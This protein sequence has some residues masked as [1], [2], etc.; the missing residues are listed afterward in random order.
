MGV[1][2]S[3]TIAPKVDQITADHL[4][5]SGPITGKVLKVYSTGSTEQ[6]VAIQLSCHEQPYKPCKGMRVVL[7]GVWGDNTGDEYIGRSMRLFRN[8]DV[9][10]GGIAVGGVEI[11]HV[12][13]I[14]KAMGIPIR[15][16]KG[17]KRNFIVEPLRDAD[18]SP[19]SQKKPE[20][21]KP[22]SHDAE[23]TSLLAALDKVTDQAG[24]DAL[25]PKVAELWKVITKE[26]GEKITAKSKEAK[27]RIEPKLA[28]SNE[29]TE[30]QHAMANR[31]ATL[32]NET[33]NP[34]RLEGYR[35]NISDYLAN[36]E[37]TPHQAEL[38][39]GMIDEKLKSIGDN[40]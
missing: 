38:L 8:P 39:M 37:L 9:K 12:T 34:K 11:S 2:L 22:A 3:Q 10:Y 26:Q 13:N 40:L 15:V 23:V 4:L 36:G 17:K 1:D 31:K 33:K 20:P 14:T 24:L 29:T 18:L 32:I 5:V 19:A 27:A 30:S 7:V 6:P 21:A 25:S 16:S 35:A 28:A